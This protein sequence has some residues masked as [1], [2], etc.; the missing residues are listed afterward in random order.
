MNHRLTTLRFVR[1]GSL[2]LCAAL[3]LVA[4]TGC[5]PGARR[6]PGLTMKGP[7]R[8]IWVTRWDFKTPRD[9]AEIME[10]AKSAGFNTVLFQVR[11][12]G[13][14]MYPSRLE[15]WADELGGRDPGY[16]PLA[17]ACKEAHR[18]GL[19]LHA[20]ANVMPGWRGKEPPANRKQLYHAR[21]DWFWRDASGRRQPL[22][23]YN[24]LNPCYPE[25]RRYLSDVMAEIVGN[26]PVDG[27]H[28]DY[29]RFPNEWNASYPKG[30]NVPDYP[31]DPRTLALFRKATGATPQSNPRAWNQWRADCVTQL[32]HDIRTKVKRA[33]PRAALTAAVSADPKRAKRAYFQD[34]GRW[35]AEG[36]VD[37]VFPMN[38]DADMKGFDGKLRSWKRMSAGFPVVTGI[39]FDKRDSGKV[40]GQIDRANGVFRSFAAF[41][42]NSMFERRDGRGRITRNAQSASRDELRRR[43]IPHMRRLADTQ[44]RLVAR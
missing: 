43:V 12:N 24:S 30:A 28:M 42:Y 26:Y 44:T 23:W 16:D 38:Y 32:V 18:R 15:P 27:L 2:A 33:N 41:A 8:A 25:V 37:A 29:V 13:T 6:G 10:N 36:L 39:M 17:V 19:Q 7:V 5:H 20:W 31:R 14:V 34:S 21:A 40:I 35:I 11:G 22:G 3:M 4:M 1:F 9:I